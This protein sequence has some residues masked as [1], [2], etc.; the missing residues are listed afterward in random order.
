MAVLPLVVQGALSDK[1]Y[2]TTASLAVIREATTHNL[3][4]IRT[5]ASQGTPCGAG[6]QLLQ[7]HVLRVHACCFAA[8]TRCNKGRAVLINRPVCQLSRLP[9]QFWALSAPLQRAP[10]FNY[11]LY[12]SPRCICVFV[13]LRSCLFKLRSKRASSP[14]CQMLSPLLVSIA[15]IAGAGEMSS[16][17]FSNIF[18]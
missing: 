12:R 11:F 9:D 7:C 13:A 10:L 15:G 3:Y 1:A 2:R 14:W 17:P 5:S 18:L 4:P 6:P 8:C 16:S